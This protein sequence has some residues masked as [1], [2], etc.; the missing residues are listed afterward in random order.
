MAV[1]IGSVLAWF[2]EAPRDQV[3]QSRIGGA[4]FVVASSVALRLVEAVLAGSVLL[5]RGRARNGVLC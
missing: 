1:A 3:M 5:M 4:C 2:G